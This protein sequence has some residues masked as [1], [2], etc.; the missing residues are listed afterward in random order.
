MGMSEIQTWLLIRRYDKLESD[1]S[2]LQTSLQPLTL[3]PGL[4]GEEL[5]SAIFRLID[6]EDDNTRVLKIRRQDSNLIPLSTLLNGSTPEKPFIVDVAGVHQF[7]PVERRSIP[8][9][10]VDALQSKLNNL[11]K[12]IEL[13]E[14]AVPDLTNAHIHA[15]EDA[16]AQLTNCVNFLDRRL[17]ELVPSAWK[18]QLNSTV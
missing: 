7:C 6:V 8:P 5:K 9:S 13:A 16:A 12:R 2:K 11:E 10:Y 14:T 15:V 17:D 1:S 4:L 18:S 3:S